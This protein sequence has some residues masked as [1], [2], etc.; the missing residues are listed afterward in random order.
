MAGQHV[1]D[2]CPSLCFRRG[3]RPEEY[4]EGRRD[5]TVWIIGLNPRQDTDWVDKRTAEQLGA[6]FEDDAV[7]SSAGLKRD[8]FF[9]NYRSVS[10][11]LFDN[12]GLPEGV[13]H[14]DLVKC[15]SRSFPPPDT[16][17]NLV[18]RNCLPYLATQIH[19]HQP[20]VILC[21]GMDVVRG[22]AKLL[23]R[24]DG[25]AET[26]YVTELEGMEMGIVNSG[27]V[28]RL[29]RLARTRL[30]REVDAMLDRFGLLR[31]VGN[32]RS[33]SPC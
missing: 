30:G 11:R 29:D 20:Q 31:S 12:L 33:G 16:D 25:A 7:P 15:S 19:N 4:L 2:R 1:C 28:G 17:A 24:S 27:F 26:G 9:R 5:S 21:N 23:G 8:P 13:A 18:I 22:V 6:A 14:T 3:Y 10:P 32:S